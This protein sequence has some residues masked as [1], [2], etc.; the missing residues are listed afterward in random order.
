MMILATMLLLAAHPAPTLADIKLLSPQAAGD[1]ALAGQF[2]NPIVEVIIPG[3]QGMGPPG[4]VQIEMLERATPTTGACARRRWIVAFSGGTG[5]PMNDARLMGGDAGIEVASRRAADC[6]SNGYVHLNGGL[7]T[8]Q[9]VAAL[10]FR[11]TLVGRC[12]SPM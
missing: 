11:S 10:A 7:D 3:T 4:F 12:T 9:A 5:G 6:P 1:V 2:H 8:T